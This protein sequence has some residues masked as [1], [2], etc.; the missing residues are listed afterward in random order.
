MSAFRAQFGLNPGKGRDR[1]S[2][3]L[4]VNDDARDSLSRLADK[5]HFC[6]NGRR[7][8]LIPFLRRLINL[9]GEREIRRHS[10]KWHVRCT[11]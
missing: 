4:T 8:E 6:H 10:K 11:L 9:N 1:N 3:T 7:S 2:A 5:Q